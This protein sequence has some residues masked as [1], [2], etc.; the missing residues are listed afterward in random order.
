[1]QVDVSDLES[2]KAAAADLKTRLGGK[3]LYGLVNNAGTGFA[4][5]PTK[6]AMLMTNF[7]GPKF[8]CDAFIPIM[9]Q[10]GGRI[11]NMGSGN[12]CAYVAQCNE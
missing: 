2:V 12:G 7:Y 9:L 8:M 1:M 6:E 4:H 11:V 5:N 3:Q 10:D